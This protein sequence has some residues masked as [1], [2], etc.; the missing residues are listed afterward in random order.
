MPD[1]IT[2]YHSL[3]S[4]CSRKVRLCL[5]EK[6][7]DYESVEIDL[8]HYEHHSEAYKAIN[9][10]GVVPTLVFNGHV[11]LESTLINEFL[12]ETYPENSLVPSSPLLKAQMR[13]WTKLVDEVCL[14]ALLI[15]NW[16]RF[17]RPRAKKWN[18]D[19]L[20]ER[21]GAIPTRERRDIWE[22]MA[23]NPYTL[24]EIDAK[25]ADLMGVM[26]KMDAALEGVDWLVDNQY[27]L[28]DLNLTPYVA[29]AIELDDQLQS[30][31]PNV[32]EWW[33]RVQA[34]PSFQAAQ[35]DPF[36]AREIML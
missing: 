34:R 7:L 22:R 14:P 19:E 28:A 5:A 36:P 31:H 9:P 17:M 6:G 10:N 3:P 25:L 2:L 20:N 11:L 24:K 21:L 15:Q 29:R 8:H 12:D 16:V 30:R 33:E 13:V 35:L 4:S 27:T 1:E 26:A 18:D 32:A 23:R